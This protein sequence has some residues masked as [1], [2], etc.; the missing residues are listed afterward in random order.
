MKPLALLGAGGHGRVVADTAEMA[1]WRDI[2]FLD[3]C[4]DE[5]ANNGVW[6]V[7]GPLG[8]WHELMRS[9]DLFIS[10]GH[11]QT[12][13][14]IL[15]EFNRLNIRQPTIVHSS[16]SISRHC[17]LDAGTVVMAGGIV[18]AFANIGSSVIVNTGAT[19]DHDCQIAEAVHI[20]PGAHLAGTVS[21]GER[22]WIG[23][24][25]SVRQNTSIGADV[26]VGAGAT[27]VDDIPDETMVTGTPARA[28]LRSETGRG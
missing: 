1:G 10:V 25:A 18:Q 15:S 2:V 8:K 20:S 19:V 3:D 14:N 27:V 12:R 16:A 23:I 6:P 9:H 7:I 22:S 13:Q 17:S 4:F 26:I 24:G 5:R 11:N 28:T 21:V